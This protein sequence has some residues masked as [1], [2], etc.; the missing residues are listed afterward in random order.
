LDANY[1]GR[2]YAYFNISSVGTS[3]TQT[4]FAQPWQIP[5]AVTCDFSANYLF[6]IG[7][8][9]ATLI[10]NIFNLLDQKY[11]TDATDGTNHDWK[12]SSVY[13]GFGRTWSMSLKIRF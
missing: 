6:K 13:Y 3:L 10:G 1:F 7:E 9:N 5:D 12:T 4:T 2:N 8:Y 11:I